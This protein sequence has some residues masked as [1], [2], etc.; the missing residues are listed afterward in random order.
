MTTAYQNDEE[1]N[2]R[3]GSRSVERHVP[4]RYNTNSMQ[5]IVNPSGQATELKRAFSKLNKNLD[6]QLSQG[7]IIKNYINADDQGRL[8]ENNR[9]LVSHGEYNSNTFSD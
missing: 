4:L 7:Q 6:R 5:F 8:N 9:M 2:L 1:N 3:H